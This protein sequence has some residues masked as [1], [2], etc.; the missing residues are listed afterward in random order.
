MA[1]SNDRFVL[2]PR[3]GVSVA[4]GLILSPA[5][6]LGLWVLYQREIIGLAVLGLTLAIWAYGVGGVRVVATGQ[7]VEFWRLFVREWRILIDGTKIT[8]GYGGD[9]PVLPAYMLE[10][11]SGK[12]ASLVK[13][14]FHPTGLAALMA[15]LAA[16]GALIPSCR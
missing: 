16:H 14:Q 4:L 13:V 1:N 10:D 5:W 7:Y 6:G 15:Y 2:R 8:E 3:P 11:R 12:R 9:L